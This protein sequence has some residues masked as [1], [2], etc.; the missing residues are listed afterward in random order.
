[1]P[2]IL[3]SK[4]SSLYLTP[5]PPL[6][7]SHARLDWE[8]ISAWLT[9]PPRPASCFSRRV[10][11]TSCGGFLSKV[12]EILFFLIYLQQHILYV[13]SHAQIMCEEE[14]EK[15]KTAIWHAQEVWGRAASCGRVHGVDKTLVLAA[16]SALT[17]HQRRSQLPHC[18]IAK[19][20]G[21]GARA[22]CN[23]KKEIIFCGTYSNRPKSS[24][25][26]RRGQRVS[27]CL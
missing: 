14:E 11:H 4:S 17:S 6:C 22:R 9:T 13:P 7:V 20:L 24:R 15:K 1:M 5:P 8:A 10:I 19:A 23:S 18:I 16:A 27:G 26:R 25:R 3:I 21:V 2:W 12:V